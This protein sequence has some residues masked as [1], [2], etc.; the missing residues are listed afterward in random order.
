MINLLIADDSDVVKK[1]LKAEIE[2][3]DSNIKVLDFAKNGIEA[4]DKTISLNPDV[5]IMDIRMPYLNGLEATKKIINDQMTPVI[6]FS[7]SSH[8]DNNILE[9]IK[10]P[11]VI[12]V[13]KPKGF[14]YGDVAKELI[15]KI[16][17][18]FK[19][20]EKVLKKKEIREPKDIIFIPKVICIG[21]STGGT[22]AIPELLKNID[23]SIT[24]PIIIIQHITEGFSTKFGDWLRNFTS[25]KVKIVS[26]KE[27]IENNCVYIPDNNA[28]LLASPDGYI[29]PSY[30]KLHPTFC[31]SVDVTF[32]SFAD[33]YSNKTM[34]ILLTGMGKDGAEGMLKIYS[35]GGYTIA[36]DKDSCVVFGMPKSAIEKNA[37]RKVLPLDSIHQ[38]ILEAFSKGLKI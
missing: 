33:A 34:A 26:K 9:I 28:H 14:N 20:N 25:R 13:E 19:Q 37:V 32:N 2:K 4:Y 36:Q 12:F 8:E 35:L 15:L 27:L 16:N 10:Y 21:A 29:Y 22:D 38:I 24:T 17:D 6:I 1:I 30:S 7:A 11:N 23:D 5:V 18:L 3:T 31:P